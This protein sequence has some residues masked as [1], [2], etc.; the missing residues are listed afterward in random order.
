MQEARGEFFHLFIQEKMTLRLSAHKDRSYAEATWTSSNPEIVSVDENGTVHAHAD[1]TALITADC[2][3]HQSYMGII[4]GNGTTE[5][6]N[7]GVT[8][9]RAYG[10]DGVI[11]VTGAPEGTA[12][13]VFD[14]AVKTRATKTATG[15]GDSLRVGS[16]V[17]VISA[18]NDVFKLGM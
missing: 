15:R 12:I 16:G 13:R 4:A 8:A 9:V 3:E 6:E 1:G 18:G 5:V 10:R 2:G 14:A 11:Y 17:F 7:P